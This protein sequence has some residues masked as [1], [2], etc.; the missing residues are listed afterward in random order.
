MIVARHEVPGIISLYLIRNVERCFPETSLNL[1]AFDPELKLTFLANSG[2]GVFR[3]GKS[4]HG[5]TPNFYKDSTKSFLPISLI[6]MDDD[7]I[8]RRVT[9]PIRNGRIYNLLSFSGLGY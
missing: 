6:Q 4:H 7:V 8:G 1:A 9:K 5:K 2:H 3:P